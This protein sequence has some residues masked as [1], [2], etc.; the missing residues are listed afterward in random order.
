MESGLITPIIC[1]KAAK[2]IA[3]YSHAYVVA[4]SAQLVYTSGSL[5]VD[6][7]TGV[8]VSEDVGEQTTRALA[9]IADVL[10]SSGSSLAH[11]VKVTIYLVDMA[12]Y[13]ACNAAYGKVFTT[14]PP[15]RTCVA[16]KG[17]P[18]N[19]KVE[20]EAIAVRKTA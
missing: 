3:P 16:V 10:E 2:P 1:E 7:Q 20:I 11:V 5:G 12:D 4:P 18:R 17:L 6:P 19:G 15:A 9:N 14:N 8:L 13:A